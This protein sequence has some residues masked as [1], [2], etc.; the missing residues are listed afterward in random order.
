MGCKGTGSTAPASE[1]GNPETAIVIP[2]AP[3]GNQ[4]TGPRADFYK[5]AFPT[6]V[7]FESKDI[8]NVMIRD[9][10][11]ANCRIRIGVL[12]HFSTNA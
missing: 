2:D 10:D 8:P 5:Q 12:T 1:G 6:A 9:L 7:A 4:I 11:M 3:K